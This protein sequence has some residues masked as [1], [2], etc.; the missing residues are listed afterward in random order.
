MDAFHMAP[1]ARSVIPALLET[2]EKMVLASWME[3]QISV[4]SLRSGQMREDELEDQSQGFL[5]EFVQALDSGEVS[6]ISGAAWT[7]VRDLLGDFCRTR[8]VQGFTPSQ[9]AT[10]VFS[11]PKGR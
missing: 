8:A 11:Q 10:F 5:R 4:G 6:D 2:H 1:S 7:S 3:N 9:T